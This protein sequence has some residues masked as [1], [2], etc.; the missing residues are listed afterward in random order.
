L[1]ARLSVFSATADHSNPP[2]ILARPTHLGHS[3]P[4]MLASSSTTAVPAG[5]YASPR[6]AAEPALA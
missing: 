1:L 4:E 2:E 6:S 3:Y 5:N